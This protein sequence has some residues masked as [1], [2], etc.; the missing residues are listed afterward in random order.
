[1]T[2]C[3]IHPAIAGRILQQK[4][5]RDGF[6]ANSSTPVAPSECSIPA[7][8]L[9]SEGATGVEELAGDWLQNP[10]RDRGRILQQEFLRD[11]FPANSSTPVAPSD[12]SIPAGILL[13]EGATG[14]EELAGDWLQNPSRDRG[15]DPTAEVSP[16]WIPR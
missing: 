4:F 9:L 8:I 15:A 16:G 12:C 6:P 3:R 14:V 2:G 1:M 13:S 10:S 11:G 5:L 7:G